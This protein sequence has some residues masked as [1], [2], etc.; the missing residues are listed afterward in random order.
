MPAPKTK[1]QCKVPC[2]EC[3]FSKTV[4]KGALGGS[5]PMV[6][7]GQ[8][9]GPFWLP[10]HMD[11]EYD[12]I[13]SEPTVVGQCAG[14]A[15][16]RANIGADKRMPDALLKLEANTEL[17][18]A[19]TSEFVSYHTGV[20]TEISVVQEIA[21]VTSEIYKQNE[22]KRFLNKDTLEDL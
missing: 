16:M 6:Y 4:E 21:A 8:I 20:P 11:K 7:V 13:D 17:A 18:F 5:D 14:A 19:S 12:N 10:C 1:Q 15:I 22:G 2:S 3:P 9:H